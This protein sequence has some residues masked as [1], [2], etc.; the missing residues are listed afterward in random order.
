MAFFEPVPKTQKTVRKFI[1]AAKNNDLASVNL[2]LTEDPRINVNV[3]NSEGLTALHVAAR[4]GHVAIVKRLL[5]ERATIDVNKADPFGFTPLM[6]AS[7]GPEDTRLEILETL[8]GAGADP[9]IAIEDTGMTAAHYLYFHTDNPFDPA[10]AYL[11][12]LTG[13]STSK[14]MNDLNIVML[15]AAP[16]V[17]PAGEVPIFTF[18]GHGTELMCEMGSVNANCM[19]PPRE[20]MLPGRILLV[21]AECGKYSFW[22]N[23]VSKAVQYGAVDTAEKKALFHELFSPDKTVAGNALRQIETA[24]GVPL[25]MYREGDEYP[26]ISFTLDKSFKSGLYL[27]PLK[28]IDFLQ[29]DGTFISSVPEDSYFTDTLFPTQAGIEK[30]RKIVA[31]IRG[32]GFSLIERITRMMG[33]STSVGSLMDTFGPGVYVFPSCRDLTRFTNLRTML[34][35]R[36]G[37]EANILSQIK[38]FK[39]LP[40][41]TSPLSNTISKN[42]YL[43]MMENAEKR[44][45]G[46]RRKSIEQQKQYRPE[47]GPAGGAGASTRRFR[48]RKAHKGTRRRFH[49]R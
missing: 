46:I 49:R 6:A 37:Q 32:P 13:I 2:Y 19:D 44:I 18:V 23:E 40:N 12:S 45:P 3:V 47:I 1:T 17:V 7:V 20:K 9:R 42:N 26:E 38:K 16:P 24:M 30:L 27:N 8:V 21:A 14:I 25:H 22:V 48:K 11:F 36:F 15:D 29:A 41:N 10:L 34:N 43:V 35:T 39:N 5:E 31:P 28:Q 33:R 4:A